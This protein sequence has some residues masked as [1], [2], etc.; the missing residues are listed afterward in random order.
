VNNLDESEL[1]EA[2]TDYLNNTQVSAHFEFID[3]F[4]DIAD[5]QNKVY[6]EVKTDHLAYAQILHALAKKNISNATAL[7][8]A[9]DKEIRFFRPPRFAVIRKFA[10]KFDPELVFTP[11]QVDKN[12]L[13]EE[14]K[15]IL[16]T[17]S[18]VITLPDLSKSPQYRFITKGNLNAIKSMTDKYRIDLDLLLDWLDGVGEQSSIKVNTHGWIVNTST[19]SMFTNETEETKK[20]T[21]ITEFGG[22]RKPKHLP[23]K[24]KDIQ[25]FESLRVRHDDLADI[26]H[27]LDRLIP[28]KKRRERGVFWTESEIGDRLANELLKLTKP[29]YVVEP[30]VGGGSLIKNIAPQVKGA[31][32]DI[33][34]RH[35]EG[36]KKVFDGY[37]WK[38]TALDVVNT[39]S[40][41]LIKEWEMPTGKVLL[42][43]NPPFG[44]SSAN[45]L[46]SK[47]DEMRDSVS[48]QLMIT[49]PP[50]L[51]KYGKGDLFLPI[52]GR[53]IEIAK[54]HRNCSL[55]FFSPLGLFCGRE[56]YMKLLTLLLKD[57]KFVKGYVFVGNYFHDIN[58]I[59]PVALSI[60]HYSP[61]SDTKLS[62]LNLEFIDKDGDNRLITLKEMTLLKDGWRYRDGSKYVKKKTQAPLGVF[63]C[64]RFNTPN[65]RVLALDLK[66]GSGA[67]L[68]QDNVRIPLGISGLP[69]EL[70]YAL[71]SLSVGAKAFGTSLSVA[72][73][74]IYFDNA[75]VHLPDFT[76]KGAIEV[77]AYAALYSLLDNYAKDRIG[78]FGANR[79]FRFGD[80]HLTRGVQYLLNSCKDCSVY[81]G[82]SISEVFE[83]LKSGKCDA[84]KLRKG[85]ISEVAKRL[86]EIGYWNYVP[87][88]KTEHD[89]ERKRAIGLLLQKKLSG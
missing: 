85:V 40:E 38:A 46:V 75:Y 64:D 53:L 70:V 27:E 50:A 26:L 43:T 49:Y 8:V 23:I 58:K 33:S 22:A 41:L 67:E 72:L 77:L 74:P 51:L 1:S 35:V 9:D 87:I 39:T 32:N 57:F 59:K 52:I 66:E 11:S 6:I 14:A 34:E 18:R 55:A 20:T 21:E 24:Q 42:Y 89:E 79:V 56:R 28:R 3:D 65:Q 47:K 4:C 12:D 16:G 68:S 44:T 88:P 7:G 31:M 36:C 76:K 81:D 84:T 80:E 37:G 71:W 19:V 78:F 17:A 2:I 62:T 73:Y 5:S 10:M 83:L 15:K 86:E 25:W 60:W 29:S 63:R 82:H 54:V 69:D 45:R 30:C 13:N 48:R 61:N